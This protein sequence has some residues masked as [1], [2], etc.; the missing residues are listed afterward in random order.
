MPQARNQECEDRKYLFCSIM[1]GISDTIRLL[2]GDSLKAKSARGVIKLSVGTGIER[3]LRLVRTMILTRILA[4]EQ[5]GLMAIVLVLV[6]VFEQLSEVGIKLSVIQ[7]KRGS[8]PEYLNA[9]WWFQAMRG[10]GL[11]TIAILIAP[12]ISSFFDKP[13]ILKLLQISLLAI[14]FRGFISPRAYVLQREYKFGRMAL[15]I[16]GS[17]LFGTIVTVGYALV[18]KN[19]WALVIGYVAEN[20]ALCFLS[21]ILAPF[22]P[23]FDIDRKCLKE[24]TSFARRIFGLPILSLIGYVTP[25]FVLGKIVTEEKLGLY[26]L[27]GQLASIP[28]ILFTKIVSPVI[29]PGFAR[30]QDNKV[31]L[32]KAVLQISKIIATFTLPL[33]VYLAG[34]ASGL[35]CILWGPRYVDATIPCVL[36]SMLVIV[37]SQ[38]IILSSTYVA[39]GQ[40]HLQRRFVI[41]MTLIIVLFIYPAVV[42]WGLIG[43]A[44]TVIVS[45]YTALLMQIFWCRRVIPLKF[46]NY[47][48]CYIP[49]LLMAFPPVIVIHMLLF[50]GVDSMAVILTAG[51]AVLFATYTI[52]F[53]NLFLA[54]NSK[55]FF[56]MD[57][58]NKTS[59]YDLAEAK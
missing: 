16:Q 48:K 57:K 45:N 33:V 59:Q 29:L 51:A 26:A 11:F 32:C 49:G 43:A 21:Y 34:C 22:T 24:L 37:K 31:S 40:P 58:L 2:Q 20:C 41:L 10:L 28:I 4:P 53:G 3:I 9:T 5:F 47:I 7:N 39:V 14:V 52:F 35:L 38:G 12:W 42:H 8:D 55:G 19:I 25:T 13:H 36:L 27:A 23:R 50:L 46:D 30:K 54:R 56:A 1:D 18:A 17:A 44:V 15:L 6:N